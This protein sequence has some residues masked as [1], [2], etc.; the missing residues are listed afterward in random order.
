L[1]A[2]VPGESKLAALQRFLDPLNG[3]SWM[4]PTG[5]I[6]V[7]K[8]SFDLGSVGSLGIR[9]VGDTRASNV[10]T[11]R[12]HRAAG[13]IPNGILSVW[14]GNERIQTINK[15]NVVA[16]GAEGPSRLYKA[17][18][19][20]YR[21]ITSSAPDASDAQTG[22]TELARLIATGPNYLAALA[23]REFARENINELIVTCTVAEH[24]NANGDPYAV[25]QCYDI[26]MDAAGVEKKMY[27][28]ACEYTLTEDGSQVTNLSFCN[29]NTIVADNNSVKQASPEGA[30]F[31]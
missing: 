21:C 15:S 16:N 19:K 5:K 17:G 28:F 23:A 13:Q 9:I 26:V 4:S 2:T 27:L 25:D 14:L 3:L 30:R 11:M 7:G 24:L 18:H 29:V 20:L 22:L 1:F 12:V 8:P 31:A 6:I 10:L